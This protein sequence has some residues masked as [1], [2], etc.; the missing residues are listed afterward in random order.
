MPT[1]PLTVPPATPA[2]LNT[3]RTAAG[4][5]ADR[6]SPSGPGLDTGEDRRILTPAGTTPKTTPDHRHN[7]DVRTL[8]FL[9]RGSTSV[10]SVQTGRDSLQQAHHTIRPVVEDVVLGVPGVNDESVPS[11]AIH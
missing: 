11:G 3:R 4:V 1:D 9:R 10:S 5:K 7:A 6:R 8:P 2:A